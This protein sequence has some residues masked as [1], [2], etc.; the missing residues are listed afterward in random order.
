MD[1]AT[2][3]GLLGALL[4]S[5]VGAAGSYWATVGGSKTQSRARLTA[6][7]RAIQARLR[8]GQQ[9]EARDRE[10]LTT[11][12]TQ[13]MHLLSALDA[14][15]Q[16]NA[17]QFPGQ[18]SG[19]APVTFDP[20]TP[21]G[22]RWL[23]RHLTDIGLPGQLPS[24]WLGAISADVGSMD[25]LLYNALSAYEYMLGYVID[26]LNETVPLLLEFTVELQ[27]PDELSLTDIAVS[28]TLGRVTRQLATRVAVIT[29]QLDTLAQI[30]AEVLRLVPGSPTLSTSV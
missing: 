2:L 1:S 18:S 4:G 3:F 13:L 29:D 27:E 25:P 19:A 10:R 22:R 11:L 23:R 30:R 8:A 15:R 16:G 12:R 7:Y 24:A 14:A 20:G 9:E 26:F 21:A 5:V 28:G 6:A 17:A